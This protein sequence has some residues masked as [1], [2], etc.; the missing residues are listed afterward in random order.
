MIE[1]KG[2]YYRKTDNEPKS[3]LVQ[4]DGVLLHVWHMSNPFYRLVSSDV[5]RL[6]ASIRRGKRFIKLPNGDRIET[7]N[8]D[9]LITIQSNRRCQIDG[10]C[11]S[12]FFKNRVVLIMFACAALL[13]GFLMFNL[14]V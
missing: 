10:T 7:D 2:A 5:F 4:F 8:L 1:F 9:A 12:R 3:V 14:L 11:S 6:P 13:G